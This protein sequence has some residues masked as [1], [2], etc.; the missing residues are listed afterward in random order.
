MFLLE[1]EMI[2]H[3]LYTI[4]VQSNI[5]EGVST[6]KSKYFGDK[7]FY[8]KILWL[9]VPI[10]IQNLI[11]N[12]VGLL[13]NIMVGQLGT[14]Q[15]SGVA[16]ANQLV[17][18]FNLLVFGGISGAGIF[19]AQYFGS[20]DFKGFRDTFRFKLILG[21]VIVLFTF[22]V[23]IGFGDNLLQMYLTS[24]NGGDA[25]ATFHFGQLYLQC[26]LLEIIPFVIVQIYAS[27]LR[28]AGETVV[29]M[30]AGIVAVL[31]N[32]LFNY[33][34]IFGNFGAPKLGV[35]GAALA[36]ALARLVECAIVVLWTHLHQASRKLIEGAYRSLR[37]PKELVHKIVIKGLPLM[38]NEVMWAGGIA[39]INQLMSIRGLNVVGA[40]N[41]A[42][43][44][45]NLFNVVFIAMG[46]CVAILVGQHLGANEF[47]KAKETA[48]KVIV[49]SI[50][51][52]IGTSVI[53]FIVAGFF[54]ALYNTSAQ[55][56]SMATAMIRIVAC[57]MPIQAFL[58]ATYF[59][60]RSGGRTLVT[61]MFDGGY[62]WCIVIPVIAILIH[63]S[64]LGIMA[65]YTIFY[66]MD[67][68]KSVVGYILLRKGIW[69]Q[70]IIE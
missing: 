50:I 68:I 16:I 36:T 40:T 24:S 37:V 45:T 51:M 57:F 66:A 38:L 64:P 69:I 1:K 35:M 30:V 32:L 26:I 2:T 48:T 12:F 49:F 31:V 47:D 46:S 59:T 65:V 25:Q 60:I 23:L 53:L 19:G 67:I 17:F 55:I 15:M 11:T 5:Y 27:M 62:S 28:E 44:V 6:V 20:H 43:T 54:P 13:D 21:I 18:V 39:V 3:F 56:R 42:N 33:I 4:K 8:K 9:A 34:L 41:I 70:N 10:M 29:P 58:H 14:E 63:F 52:T 7:K 61:F 22:G